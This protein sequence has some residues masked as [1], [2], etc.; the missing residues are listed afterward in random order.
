MTENMTIA[1]VGLGVGILQGLILLVLA[2]IKSD[3]KDLWKRIYDHYH[4]VTC[5]NSECTA[6][7]TGNVIVPGAR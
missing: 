7:K 6:L 2:G 1:L 5:D 3:I 4:E